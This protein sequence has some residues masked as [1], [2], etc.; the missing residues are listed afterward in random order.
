MTR[1]RATAPSGWLVSVDSVDLAEE[2]QGVATLPQGRRRFRLV[3]AEDL[4]PIDDGNTYLH[5]G[6][7]IYRVGATSRASRVCSHASSGSR[8]RGTETSTDVS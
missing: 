8:G 5:E 4:V 2:R 6:G 3:G 7:E 1:G